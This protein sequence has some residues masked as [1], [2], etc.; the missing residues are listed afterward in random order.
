MSADGLMFCFRLARDLGKTIEELK[1]M[2][3]EEFTY[4]MAFYDYENQQ[5]NQSIKKAEKR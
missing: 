4:W 3:S 1:S 2:S 5:K